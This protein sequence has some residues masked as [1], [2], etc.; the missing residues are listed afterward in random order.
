[1]KCPE[2]MPI[3]ESLSRRL[4]GKTT[5]TNCYIEITCFFFLVTQTDSMHWKSAQSLKGE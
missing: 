3:T 2:V 5:H 1:M 4:H